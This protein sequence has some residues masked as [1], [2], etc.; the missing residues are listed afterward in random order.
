MEK[1]ADPRMQMYEHEEMPTL[2]CYDLANP[3]KIV[4]SE[5]QLRGYG[6]FGFNSCCSGAQP[7]AAPKNNA[8]QE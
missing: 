4:D 2:D 5:E 7:K 3:L 6:Q 8:A 1:K